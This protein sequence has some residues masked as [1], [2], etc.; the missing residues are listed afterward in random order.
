VFKTQSDLKP[1][2]TVARAPGIGLVG[3]DESSEGLRQTLADAI[4]YYK[5]HYAIDEN[6]PLS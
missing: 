4:T 1:D 2:H 5:E 3:G 6:D